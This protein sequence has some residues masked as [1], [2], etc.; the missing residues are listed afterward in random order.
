MGVAQMANKK[1]ANANES[2]LSAIAEQVPGLSVVP[3]HP[4][5]A[6]GRTLHPDLFDG[7]LGLVI[8]AESF[9]WHGETAALT[10]DCW[11]YNA[12]TVAGYWVIRFSWQQVMNHPAYVVWVLLEVVK[13]ARRHANVARGP[14]VLAA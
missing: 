6:G 13:L 5:E 2:T 9:Q 4:V 3:Q 14:T 11:R 10:R 1:R 12:F 7:Q 8:E